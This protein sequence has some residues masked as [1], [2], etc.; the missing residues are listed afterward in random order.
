MRAEDQEVMVAGK[1]DLE[2]MG[3]GREGT[4]LEVMVGVDTALEVDIVAVRKDT[5]LEV[6]LAAVLVVTV[7][8]TSLV[9]RIRT[10]ASFVLRSLPLGVHRGPACVGRLS[11]CLLV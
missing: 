3:A 11:S 9:H 5:A 1:T 10:S 6:K 7:A 2:D 8:L 4:A